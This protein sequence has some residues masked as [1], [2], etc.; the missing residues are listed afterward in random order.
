[1][2]HPYS[3]LVFIHAVPK[4][5]SR[6]VEWTIARCLGYQIKLDW[7]VQQLS[8]GSLRSELLWQGSADTGAAITSALAGWQNIYFE[9]TQLPQGE[10]SGSRWQYTPGLG[11]KHRTTDAIGNVMIGEDEMRA[12]LQRAGSNALELQREMRNLLADAWDSE[13]EPLRVTADQSRVIW[14]HRVG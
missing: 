13:L 5:V 9:V 14:L 3:G 12:A 7:T 2:E 8:P 11:I 10:D 6:Q 4:P 1:M